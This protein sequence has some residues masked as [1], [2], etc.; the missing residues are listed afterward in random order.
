MTDGDGTEGDVTDG[1][2]TNGYG[3]DGDGTDGDTRAQPGTLL[4]YIYIYIYCIY[5]THRKLAVL[6]Q[7]HFEQ[8][9]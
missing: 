1:D 5:I 6:A 3:T 2:G 4:V 9:N 7:S 8:I